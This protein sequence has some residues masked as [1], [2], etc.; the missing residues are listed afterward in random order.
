V[1]GIAGSMG[2]S[3]ER[4]ATL[5]VGEDLNVGRYEIEFQG[6]HGSQQPTHFRVEAAFKVRNQ[7]H[8]VGVLSPAL[9][10]F[11]SQQSPIGRAMFRSSFTDDLYLI[12]SGFSE[13]EQNR[14]TL[15]VLIRPM[16]IWMWLGGL[17]IVLGTIVAVWPVRRRMK[18][19]G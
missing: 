11:P 1:L 5:K 13:I 12:L 4:E 19:E 3:V 2:Y 17:V 10:F 7:G 18:D 6:L 8:D 15:K 16:V 14:A 9:K